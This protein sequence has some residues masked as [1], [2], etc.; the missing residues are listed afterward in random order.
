MESGGDQYVQYRTS[1]YSRIKFSFNYKKK[2]K[3]GAARGDFTLAQ[4]FVAL[5]AGVRTFITR[6]LQCDSIFTLSIAVII[7]HYGG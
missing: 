3:K 1:E 2:K 5:S 6:Y 4:K 7:Y